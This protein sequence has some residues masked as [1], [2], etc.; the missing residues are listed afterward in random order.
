MSNRIKAIE[1]VRDE[2]LLRIKTE[3]NAREFV[4]EELNAGNFGNIISYFSCEK[5]LHLQ[6][7]LLYLK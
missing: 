3:K 5:T 4:L 1:Q 7:H 2:V 6:V